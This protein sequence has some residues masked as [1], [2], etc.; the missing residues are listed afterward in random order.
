MTSTKLQYTKDIDKYLFYLKTTTFPHYF[1]THFS[2]GRSYTFGHW[3]ELQ[4]FNLTDM[5]NAA[6][7]QMWTHEINNFFYKLKPIISDKLNQTKILS[8]I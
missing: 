1:H 7:E 8:P 4:L 5:L 2:L 6:I 3:L